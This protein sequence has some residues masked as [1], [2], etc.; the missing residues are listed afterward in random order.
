MAQRRDSRGRFAST[1]GGQIRSIKSPGRTV[2]GGGT[3]KSGESL[4]SRSRINEINTNFR[5]AQHKSF[6]PYETALGK[7][8]YASRKLKKLEKAGAEKSVIEKAQKD[9]S[10][11]S[12]TTRAASKQTFAEV[13][14]NRRRLRG[15][16]GLVQQRRYAR[17]R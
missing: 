7:S 15:A 8:S 10:A 14:V 1:G 17:P 9:Y 12:A 5:V 13:K 2:K 6:K 3:R 16:T 4:A 11:K